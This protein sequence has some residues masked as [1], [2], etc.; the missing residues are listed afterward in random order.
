MS[1]RLLSEKPA[2]NSNGPNKHLAEE[3]GQALPTS[4]PLT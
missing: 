2:I 3:R 4:E 1:S